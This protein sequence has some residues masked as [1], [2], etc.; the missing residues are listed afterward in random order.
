MFVYTHR[1]GKV[2][3]LG[4][5]KSLA[6]GSSRLWTSDALISSMISVVVGSS[7][8]LGFDS[9]WL[10]SVPH[11]SVG[12]L[13]HLV[14]AEA[15][16]H[17]HLRLSMDSPPDISHSSRVCLPHKK[18][19]SLQMSRKSSAYAVRQELCTGGTHPPQAQGL[20]DSPTLDLRPA[21]R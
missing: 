1:N 15:Q 21:G 3:R 14:A 12:A 9:T 13:V 6:S 11:G 18:Q 7:P 19:T 16:S 10:R 8:L 20:L 5:S 4:R 2:E 17:E